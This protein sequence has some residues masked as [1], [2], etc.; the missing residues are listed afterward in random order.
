MW[1]KQ[2]NHRQSSSCLG[3]AGQVSME[4]CGTVRDPF[5]RARRIRSLAVLSIVA[6]ALGSLSTPSGAQ[7]T[8]P[9]EWTW[10]GGSTLLGNGIIQ[11]VKGPVGTPAPGNTPGSRASAA[12]WTDKS[13]NLWLFSGEVYQEYHNDLWMLNPSTAQWTLVRASNPLVGNGA[14]DVAGVYGTLGT[15]SALDTPGGRLGSVTWTDASGH[16][17]LFGGFGIDSAGTGG[18]LNDLWE[19]NPTTSA[20]TWITGSTAVTHPNGQAGV[21]GTLGTAASTNT[22]GARMRALS[23]TDSH[24]N[25]WLFGGYG[26]DSADAVGELN[27]LW[28]FNTA[29]G[30]WTW[31]AGANNF[32]GLQGIPPAFA[33]WM[34][35]ASGNYP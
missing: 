26:V 33:S 21:Y 31:M 7:T 27:D 32:G 28:M 35:F 25:L 24:G 17:W 11:T 9:N 23:W 20:W 4:L 34:T 29:S 12:T 30:E 13:G 14:N 15:P 5:G 16:L 2:V 6:L 3:T 1:E 18:Y 10:Y 19:F 22:P 8:A